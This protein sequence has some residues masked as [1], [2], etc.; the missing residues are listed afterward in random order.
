MRDIYSSSSICGILPCRLLLVIEPNEADLMAVASRQSG[1]HTSYIDAMYTYI[2]THELIYIYIFRISFRSLHC[3]TLS[4]VELA[5]WRLILD[6]ALVIQIR[7]FKFM[8]SPSCVSPT[9][10]R[11]CSEDARVGRW[12]DVGAVQCM[13]GLR[14]EVGPHSASDGGGTAAVSAFRVCVVISDLSLPQGGDTGE[15]V[16]G[17]LLRLRAALQVEQ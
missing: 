7:Y 8:N 2:Y 1:I 4:A 5:D 9:N 3:N 10:P 16:Q 15:N 12:R 13:A 6:E 11:C 17:A 14:Y